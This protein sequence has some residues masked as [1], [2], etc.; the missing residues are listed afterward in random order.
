MLSFFSVLAREELCGPVLY[1]GMFISIF[2]MRRQRLDKRCLF[3]ISNKASHSSGFQKCVFGLRLGDLG[4]GMWSFSSAKALM[5]CTSSSRSTLA[6]AAHP[7]LVSCEAGLLLA[8]GP[9]VTC[10]PFETL[11]YSLLF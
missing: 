7:A 11:F 9:C 8:R 3:I 5:V 6:K 4:H 2:L 10:K 1:K